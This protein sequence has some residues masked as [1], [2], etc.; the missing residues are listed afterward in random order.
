[1]RLLLDTHIALWAI[2]DSPRLSAKA[3]ELI[4]DPANEIL[5]SAATIWE[6]SIKH[7]LVRG[8]P[9]DMPISGDEAIGYFRDA[10]FELLD[11]SGVH[12]AAIEGLPPIHTDPFDR[13]LVAQA[14]AVPL[15]LLTGDARVAAYT[16]LAIRV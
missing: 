13:L 3:R 12:A 5:I 7:A 14:L 8:A 10:G 16:D 1:V 15:R 9:G 4:D 2:T 6:I 11:V